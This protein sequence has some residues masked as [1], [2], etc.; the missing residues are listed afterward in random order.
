MQKIYLFLLISLTLHAME[1]REFYKQALENSPYLKGNSLTIQQAQNESKI[2]TR[3]QNPTLELEYS[4]FDDGNGK[5]LNFSQPIRLWGVGDAQEALGTNLQKS[6][7]SAYKLTKAVFS[8]GLLER[9]LAYKKALSLEK[10]SV[11]EIEIA[12]K[13]F[14][15]SKER[16]ENGTIPKADMIQAK[17]TYKLAQAK[18]QQ[19][20]LAT[21]STRYEMIAFSGLERDEEIETEF[22]IKP[23]S[24][25]SI[26]PL[27]EYRYAATDLARSKERLYSNKIEWIDL[28]GEY[29]GEPQ[30][31]IYRVGVSIPLAFFNQRKEEKQKA[32]LEAKQNELL[33][34]NTE[35]ALLFDLKKLKKERAILQKLIVRYEEGLKEGE[36][37]LTLFQEAY[38]I[39]SINI[40][41]ILQV[42]NGLIQTKKTLIEAKI[43]LERNA[44]EQN[45]LQGVYNEN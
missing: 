43:K 14:D 30:D 1:F 13:I 28:Y 20:K 37:L 36:E 29:E 10:L 17:L 34:Q 11:N 24:S 44:L 35:N 4:R 15:I 18:M 22:T 25:N 9:Y 38:K 39:A 41:Q 45:Y 8:E 23:N 31:D 16:F 3:Y 40:V 32:M 21:L 26:N 6:A 42:K 19:A 5:R 27:L 33:A 12:K 7:T 2:A